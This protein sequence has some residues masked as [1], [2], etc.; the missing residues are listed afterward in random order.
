MLLC[1]PGLEIVARK[2]PGSEA[3]AAAKMSAWLHENSE[4]DIFKVVNNDDNDSDQTETPA[5][6]LLLRDPTSSEERV[7]ER[8]CATLG[9]RWSDALHIDRIGAVKSTLSSDWSAF[10]DNDT[11]RQQ[12][13]DFSKWG[14]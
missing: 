6:A 11:L 14:R 7:L 10:F 5:D 8:Q 4:F 12:Y 1:L 13:A 3:L 9:E 2:H